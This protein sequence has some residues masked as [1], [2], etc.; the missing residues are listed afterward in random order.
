MRFFDSTRI[1]FYVPYYHSKPWSPG[2]EETR[3][4]NCRFMRG[5]KICCFVGKDRRKK[6][7]ETETKLLDQ[8]LYK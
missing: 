5:E 4:Q 3:S 6:K 7:K 2:I 8:K 1:I